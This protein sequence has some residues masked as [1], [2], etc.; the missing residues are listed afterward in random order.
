MIEFSLFG[1]QVK[2]HPTIWASLAVMAYLLTREEQGLAGMSLF[3]VAAFLCLF[4]HEMGHALAGRWLGGGRPVIELEWLGGI[5][6]NNVSRLNRTGIILTTAAGPLTSLALMIPVLAG[7][8]MAGCSFSLAWQQMQ[9]MIIFE[10]PQTLL[11]AYPPM[12]ILFI[13]QVVQVSFWW[14]ILNLLPIFP[15]DGGI[16]MTNLMRRPRRMH[17][18]SMVVA[19][20]L[21]LASFALGLYAMVVI[22]MLLVMYNHRGLQNSPY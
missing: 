11:D 20:V 6:S 2:I 16:I 10:R 4:A 17:L 9:N 18:V 14:S 7:L 13:S 1:V 8:M 21:A 12:M 15:L 19:G 22:L 3:V 5:C